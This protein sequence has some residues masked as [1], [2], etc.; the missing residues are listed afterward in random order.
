MRVPATTEAKWIPVGA[1][2]APRPLRRAWVLIHLWLGL[3]LGVVGRA[4]RHHGQRARVR[5]GDRRRAQ[6]ATLCDVRQGGSR[7]LTSTMSRARTSA[8]G[9]GARAV[10]LRLPQAKRRRWSCSCA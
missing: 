10:N 3:T 1:P 4:R 9:E 6:S 8:A 7:C 2:C 5:P